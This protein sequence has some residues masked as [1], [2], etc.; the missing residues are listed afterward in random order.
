MSNFQTLKNTLKKLETIQE[1]T[2][3]NPLCGVIYHE[4]YE[5]IIFFNEPSGGN[6][7]ISGYLVIPRRLTMEEWESKHG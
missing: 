5:K 7:K 4:D 2:V 3:K 1:K 6:R